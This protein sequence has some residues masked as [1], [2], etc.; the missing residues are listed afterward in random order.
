MAAPKKVDYE[1]IE[2]G[3]RAGILSPAQLATAYTEETG[4][5]VSH[6]AIIKHF[7]KLGVPRDLSAKVHAKA[8]AMVA[9][10]MVTGKV[11]SETTLRDAEIIDDSAARVAQV[12]IS[13]RTDIAKT[14]RLVMTLLSELEAATTNQEEV[15]RLFEVL[16]DE[17]DDKDRL[18]K[19][20]DA[21]DKV[22]SLPGRAGTMKSLAES[23]GR[24][25]TLERQAFGIADSD[26]MPP[27]ASQLENMTPNEAA[28]RIAFALALCLRNQGTINGNS[29]AGQNS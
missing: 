18:R 21:L 15:E 12:R 17:V 27:P 11:S 3:W 2:P 28:R 6:T 19:M 29:G 1:R 10:A 7:R 16:A 23:L 4:V 13:H 20:Q 5:Q 24:L 14:R 26:G 8:D 25:V 9:E 22:M